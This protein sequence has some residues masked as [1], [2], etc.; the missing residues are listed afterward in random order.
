MS[1]ADILMALYTSGA[2]SSEELANLL[3]LSQRSVR[4]SLS[5]LVKMGFVERI[6]RSND[7]AFNVFY[8]LTDK[9][10]EVCRRLESDGYL[11]VWR[12]DSNGLQV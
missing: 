11:L 7:K 6:V 3:D 2:L 12:G 1:Q 8:V 10:R 9:G 5:G 4:K